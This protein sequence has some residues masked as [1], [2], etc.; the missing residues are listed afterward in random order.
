MDN[1]QIFKQA[2]RDQVCARCGNGDGRGDCGYPNPEHVCAIQRYLPRVVDAVRR[3]KSDWVADYVVE[4]RSLVCNQCEDQ[5]PAGSC[6]RRSEA[7]CALDRYF[8]RVID[9]I[10]QIDQV[11]EVLV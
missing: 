6:V 5:S 11:P 2:I 1:W 9:A 3:A 8:P 7:T 4:L 10:E